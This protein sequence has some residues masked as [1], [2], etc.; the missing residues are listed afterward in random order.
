MKVKYRIF[1]FFFGLFI[2]LFPVMSVEAATY[3]VSVISSTGNESVVGTYT[4]YAAAK[5]AMNNY[6]STEN[7][8][9]VIKENGK[10]VNAKYAIVR[11]NF[12]RN[13]PLAENGNNEHRL[14]PT[15]SS[16]E[17]YTTVH[18]AYGNDAAFIDYDPYGGTN[19]RIK[20]KISGY[21]GWMNAPYAT[22]VPISQLEASAWIASLDT[23]WLAETSGTQVKVMSAPRIG[24]RENPSTSANVVGYTSQ[25]NVY[26][27]TEKKFDGKYTWYHVKLSNSSLKTY[28]EHYGTGCL[29]H[30]YAT[31][32]SQGFTNLGLAPSFLNKGNKYYS[33]DGNYY[34][35][36]I[37]A[38]LDDYRENTSK[39]AV[40]STTI[41][42]PYYLY[43]PVHSKTRYTA[44]DF[45]QGI[46][47]RG[48]TS[49]SASVMYG[50]G[51][52]FIAS[53]NQYGVNALLTFSAAIN[54]SATG[55]SAIA[56]D[57]NN[58]FGHNAYGSNPYANATTYGSVS[59]SIMAHARM[60]G[61]SYN[62][63][64]DARYYGGHYGNKQSGMNVKYATDPY[65]GEKAAMNAFITDNSYGLQ[66]FNGTT[67]GVTTRTGTIVRKKP[68]NGGQMIYPLK[69]ISSD[70]SHIPLTV[71]DKVYNENAYWYKIYTDP[72]LNSNQDLDWSGTYDF[73][74]SYGYVR[75]DE[76]YVSN[77]QPVI[78]AHDKTVN[79][80]SSLNLLDG[81]SASDK[82]D[83]NLTSKINVSGTV[84][85]NIPGVYDITYTVSDN[86][87]FSVSKTIKVTVK[88]EVEPTISASNRQVTQYTTFDPLASVSAKDVV[89]GDLTS[90]IKVVSNTVNMNK[91]GTYKVVYEVTNSKGKKATKEIS[92]TVILNEKP[93]IQAENR[94]VAL[95]TTFDPLASV[96]AND[97]EDGPI[98]NI[99][100][101]ENTVN[102]EKLGTYKVIYKVKDTANQEVTKSIE[103][104]VVE[105]VLTK[106]NGRFYL[107]SL[108]AKN[109]K[110]M[111]KGYN[112]IDGIDNTLNENIV[113]ELVLK[114]EENN[115][116]E[117]TQKLTRLTD[118]KQMDMPV[119]SVD[120][121][122][123]KYSW[124]EDEIDISK[125]KQGNYRVYVRSESNDY[126][127]ESIVQNI[128]FNTQEV[129]YN[130]KGKYL[131]LLNDYF[132]NDIPIVFVVRD[133][134]IENKQTDA[135]DIQYTYIQKVDLKDEIL[136]MDFAAYSVGVDMRAS[137]SLKRKIILENIKTFEKT[138]VEAPVTSGPFTLQL[139][140]P[141]K[142]GLTKEKAW[143]SVQIDTS[144]IAKG[145]YRI[146]ITNAS[147]ITDYGEMNDVLFA[148]LSG[149]S[150]TVKDRKISLSLNESLRN[151]IELHIK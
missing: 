25:G 91:V 82:E 70:V 46:I 118:E 18:A 136:H 122:N 47:N 74:K 147:N 22:I 41:Y 76:L 114:N 69:N 109:E 31:Y 138:V 10:I 8:V 95:H 60:T 75:E 106:K 150:G 103:V 24:I 52:H 92:V 85:I 57:K 143:S 146:Y 48:Y 38:M 131:T 32:N 139:L 17:V 64:Y 36:T 33:F 12:D 61:Q 125:I 83:G 151:R 96:S 14:Y 98:S 135:A 123:Y 145:D 111:I 34:Y 5:N 127:S 27:F 112:T 141:D 117:Y 29:I 55:T 137:A 105:K 116:V 68:S 73:E 87:Q 121:K 6:P 133:E 144:K 56:R 66:E 44:D 94:E 23:S 21:T 115:Q 119:L 2:S 40:N 50:E 88:G 149:A 107:S 67:I 104:K 59:E 28:Y 13:S 86:Q 42:Y 53:Q 100:V 54:E 113:Y 9:A 19:G 120:G 81:V 90:K 108:E 129:Q 15:S 110:L 11:L 97:K 78:T 35:S 16:G 7:N 4:D 128:L 84:Y 39:R 130:H 3:V 89:E 101:V 1:L 126:Y 80:G 124:F 63:P 58:L 148:D 134:K 99:I 45:N 65:W 142:F 140:Q 132:S 43:L 49:K 93:V 20:I 102:T 30:Y 62:N 79:V 26:T 51:I 71:I 37:S 72:A 77:S